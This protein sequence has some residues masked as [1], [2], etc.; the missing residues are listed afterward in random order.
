M[1]VPKDAEILRYNRIT[2]DRAN[3]DDYIENIYNTPQG[4]VVLVIIKFKF[5]IFEHN[6]SLYI[7][8][9]TYEN[10]KFT[11]VPLSNSLECSQSLIRWMEN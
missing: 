8:H 5:K 11:A 1:N 7:H 2:G 6:G 3:S 10:G 9:T 4:D